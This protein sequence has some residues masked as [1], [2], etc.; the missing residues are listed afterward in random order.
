MLKLFAVKVSRVNE[1]RNHE[2]IEIRTYTARRAEI[3]AIETYPGCDAHT[4]REFIDGTW[5]CAAAHDD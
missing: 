4:L 3:L 5:R 1:P 2:N